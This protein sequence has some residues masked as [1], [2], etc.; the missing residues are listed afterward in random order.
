MVDH[1]GAARRQLYRSGVGG[2]DLVLDLKARKERHVVAVAFHAGGHV[3]HDV[4]HELP[5]LL[6]D[7]VGVDEDLANVRVEVIPNGANHQAGFLV[8][9]VGT[10]LQALGVVDCPPELQEVVEVPLKLV[11]RSPDASC[12]G[13]KA[14]AAGHLELVHGLLKFLAILTFN[15]A[16]NTAPSRVVWHEHQV[17]TGK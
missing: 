14:H 5:R 1:E 17:T 7:V 13:N 12:T 16:R 8:N 15:A 2:F 11:N 10:R 6:V 9:E 4:Q 3:G